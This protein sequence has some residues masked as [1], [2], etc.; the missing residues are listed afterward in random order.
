[1]PKESPQLI[2]LLRTLH[3]LHRQISDLKGRQEHG[4]R[5]I[6]AAE[7][8]VQ[9]CEEDAEKAKDEAKAVR[10]DAD[11]KQLQLKTNENKVKELQAKLNAASS[12]R[13]YQIL[14]EQIAADEMANSVLA[15]EILES[16][17]KVDAYLES[18]K[19]A[20]A[21]LVSAKK[22]AEEIRAEVAAAAP[23][24]AADLARVQAE[25]AE[26]E[27]ELPE[28]ILEFYRRTTRNGGE[29]ALAVLE[30]QCCGGCHQQ[31]PLNQCSNVML[32]KPVVCKSCGRLLYLAE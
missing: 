16:F 29:E 24:I 13:E 32:G 18:V 10:V 4:P 6:Q 12:N 20:D 11:K 22:V 3:R 2:E 25:L 30:G 14:K 9:R 17:D 5:Q 26:R 21:V 7:A 19:K 31:M 28:D 8:N 1:M 23:L 27:K 15:D